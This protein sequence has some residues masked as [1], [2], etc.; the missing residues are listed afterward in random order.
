MLGFFSEIVIFF[1][2]LT[3][4][5]IVGNAFCPAQKLLRNGSP[6]LN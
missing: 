2:L 5:V 4:L 6:G 3:C 1:Q